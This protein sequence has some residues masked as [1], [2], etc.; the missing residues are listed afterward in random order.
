MTKANIIFETDAL[1]AAL[2]DV[3]GAV[4]RRN[5]IPILAN[6]LIQAEASGTVRLTTSDLDVMVTRHLSAKVDGDVAFTIEAHRLAD[7]IGSF[8]PG[9]QTTIRYDH[10]AAVVTSGRARL[11]F[12]TLPPADFPNL[13]QKDVSARFSLEAKALAQAIGAVRHAVS[14]EETRYYLNGVLL[15]AAGGKLRYAATDGHRLARF[16]ADLP[17]G[18]GDLPDTILR[19]RCI[20]LIR[21]AAETRDAA[22]DVTVGD[23]KVT[24]IVGDYSMVAKVVDGTFPDYVR[25]IPTANDRQVVVDRDAL[26]EAIGRVALATS[27]KV[28][29]VKLEFERDLLRASVRSPEHGD[30]I[31]EVQCDYSAAPTEIGFNSRYLRDALGVFDVDHVHLAIGDPASPV[32]LTSPKASE[33]TLVLMPMRI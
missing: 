15:H 6:V 28:R 12:A 27:D 13:T 5:T 14:N 25:V 7:V 2:R 31:D 8:A 17:S 33:V 16:V 9:S 1:A 4:H 32:L 20:D 23:G 10:P 26:H 30:A 21:S 19:T 22:I 24:M 18:A 29:V 11:R 3:R